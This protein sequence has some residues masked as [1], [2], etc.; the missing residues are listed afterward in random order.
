M[1]SPGVMRSSAPRLAAPVPFPVIWEHGVLPFLIELMPKWCGPGHAISVTRGKKRE[2]RR[3][4][5]MTAKPISKARKVVIAVHVQD[6]L[7]DRYRGLVSFVFSVGEVER[8]TWARGLGKEM[9]D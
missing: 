3:I 8:L 1:D 4:C 6:L 2:A 7:P 9:P 5:I